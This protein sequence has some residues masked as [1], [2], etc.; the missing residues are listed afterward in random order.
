LT[1][2][3]FELKEQLKGRTMDFQLKPSFVIVMMFGVNPLKG[4]LLLH[5]DFLLL[6]LMI[7]L[8]EFSWHHQTKME[9]D[10]LLLLQ[11]RSLM[12]ILKT[13][14]MTMLSLFLT[15]V[16]TEQVKLLVTMKFYII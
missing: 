7:L 15:W 10:L 5:L 6:I 11:E 4:Y 3:I 8:V 13:Q 1:S 2:A 16:K 9:Y 14:V 12:V